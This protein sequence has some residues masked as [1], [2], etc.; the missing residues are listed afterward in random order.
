MLCSASQPVTMVMPSPENM[1]A[2]LNS[3]PSTLQSPA[4]GCQHS[5]RFYCLQSGST[6]GPVAMH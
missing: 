6:Q 3:N 2:V 4:C 1:A 5:G